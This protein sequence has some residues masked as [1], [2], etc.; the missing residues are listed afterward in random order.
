MNITKEEPEH[1]CFFYVRSTKEGKN[2]LLG[3]DDTVYIENKSEKQGRCSLYMF[4]NIIYAEDVE[5]LRQ[6]ILRENTNVM[7]YYQ[8][9]LAQKRMFDCMKLLLQDYDFANL[10]DDGKISFCRLKQMQ[11][12]EYK[13]LTEREESEDYQIK[14]PYRICWQTSSNTG[15]VFCGG[16][17]MDAQVEHGA[18]EEFNFALLDYFISLLEFL[19][20]RGPYEGLVSIVKCLN[21]RLQGTLELELD[22]QMPPNKSL[23]IDLDELKDMFRTELNGQIIKAANIKFS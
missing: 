20:E 1:V 11:N 15:K 4:V 13:S 22:Y 6:I 10:L 16:Y 5:I 8:N 23:D 18:L 12:M 17:V 14:R 21:D 2:I 19:N 7:V 9:K 3:A